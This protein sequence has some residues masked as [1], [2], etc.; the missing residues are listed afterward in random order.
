MAEVKISALGSATSL[1]GSEAVPVVQAGVTRRTTTQDIAMLLQ[2]AVDVV[3]QA[4]SVEQNARAADV[5]RLSNQISNIISAGGGAI[6]VNSNKLSAVSATLNLHI[7]A[8]SLNLADEIVSRVSAINAASAR[9]TAGASVHG[10]QSVVDALSSRISAIVAGAVSVTSAEVS[11]LQNT[12][13]R[14]SAGN[15]VKGRQSV[16]NALSARIS[17]LETHASTASDAATSANVHANNASAAATS[18]L[19]YICA[20]S[21]RTTAAASVHGLQSI[22]QALSN[23][24]SAAAAAGATS[25]T[26]NE[27][28]AAV[29]VSAKSAATS[30]RGL[31]SVVDQLSNRV[32]AVVAGVVSVT[33]NELSAASATAAQGRSVISAALV[34]ETNNRISA[35]NVLSFRAS[36]ISNNLSIET[37][38][39]IAADDA[40]SNLLSAAALNTN[41]VLNALSNTISNNTATLNTLIIAH[42]TLSNRVSANSATGGTASVTSAELSILFSLATSVVTKCSVRNSAGVSVQ[43]LQ[44]VLNALSGKAGGGGGGG[45]V[46]STK[47]SNVNSNLASAINVVSNTLSALAVAHNLLSN[48][49]SDNISVDIGQVAAIASVDTHAATASLA[50]TSADNHAATASA[51]ATSVDTRVNTVSN[52]VSALTS[53][54]DALSNLVSNALSAGDAV[55]NQVSILSQQVSVLSQKVSVLSAGIGIPQLRMLQTTAT[56]SAS[57]LTKISGLSITLVSTKT[58]QVHAVLHHSHSTQ[59]TNGFGFGVSSPAATTATG[60]WRGFTSVVAAGGASAV[61]GYFN[62]AGFGSIT[63][64]ATPAASATNYRTELDLDLVNVTSGTL[65]LKARTSAATVGAI[66]VRAG[67]YI[68]AFRLN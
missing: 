47:V 44:S 8:V 34:V 32:S 27:L 59:G 43:G 22:V 39:R 54:H 46:T 19:N 21:A 25:V 53:A 6:S 3:S 42:N 15:S 9:T 51:A 68:Q 38:A 40:F 52:L 14:N 4:L 2:P 64:S 61:M 36:V 58:Y 57:G 45:S 11:L 20:V 35:D 56:I 24:I 28:S 17:D 23:R 49:V 67:S 5:N 63:Y 12:S 62:Q 13:V 7:N 60:V 30:V 37:A 50:A 48:A 66:D 18:V 33:S 41:S 16:F 26:S 31:Q 29:K 10:P 65:Q 1:V 55:S